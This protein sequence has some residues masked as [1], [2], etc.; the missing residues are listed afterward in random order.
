MKAYSWRDVIAMA[1]AIEG[2]AEDVGSQT[3]TDLAIDIRILAEE[4]S[5]RD[6]D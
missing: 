6:N 5:E 1:E 2:F 3:I 4:L